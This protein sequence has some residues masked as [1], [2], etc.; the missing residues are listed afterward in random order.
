MDEILNSAVDTACALPGT[1]VRYSL[2]H[3]PG[4]WHDIAEVHDGRLAVAVGSSTDPALATRL[5]S[6]VGSVLRATGDPVAA[7][8]TAADST[9]GG[10]GMVALCAVIDRPTAQLTYSS[11][12][13]RQLVV[14]SPDTAHTVLGPAV[15]RPAGV[16]LVPAA[17]VL[18]CTA[19]L[20]EPAARLLEQIA[21]LHPEQVADQLVG[22]LPCGAVAVLYRQAPGPMS[23]TVPA[24]PAS[25]AVIR[26]ELRHWL[27][28]A[29]VDSETAADTLLA[30]G[31][32]ASNATEHSVL[33]ADHDVELTV[34]AVVS[35]DRLLF[36]VAD[37]GRWKPPPESPGHRGHGIRLINALVDDADLVTGAQG[38]TVQMIK[39]W[40]Q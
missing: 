10:A 25:L 36:T 37:N 6:E 14:T 23:V 9:A 12:G 30:V 19:G 29:G 39:E 3:S 31:E 13:D 1:A 2:P 7:L 22:T 26:S 20:T 32:A 15:G 21:M 18:L 35:G 40:H 5:R 27:A 34:D 28:V 38:T 17:T 33:G 11:V 16:R 8:Q 24:D 4:L